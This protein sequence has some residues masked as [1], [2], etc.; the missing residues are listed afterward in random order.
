M[1][2]SGGEEDSVYA[3]HEKSA[4]P[5]LKFNKRSYEQAVFRDLSTGLERGRDCPAEVVDQ[6]PTF[7]CTLPGHVF[8]SG[9][10]RWKHRLCMCL[11]WALVLDIHCSSSAIRW[12]ASCI[13]HCTYECTVS[14][15]PDCAPNGC[16]TWLHKQPMALCQTASVQKP[17]CCQHMQD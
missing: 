10:S 12:Q 13:R 5:W 16:A 15:M 17:C 3:R 7:Q 11:C 8:H 14:C 1:S 9:D 6:T 2:T 4:S